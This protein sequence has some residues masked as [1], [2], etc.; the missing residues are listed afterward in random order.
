MTTDRRKAFEEKLAQ[1]KHQMETGLVD[2][3]KTLR[4]AA[5]ALLGGDAE[6]RRT[7]K[8]EGH[9]LRGIAGTYGHEDLTK[10]AARLEQKASLAP[11][12]SVAELAHELADAAERTGRTSVA[13]PRSAP[14][15]GTRPSVPPAE[16]PL[17]P[18]ARLPPNPR[19]PASRPLSGR[20]SSAPT[21]GT[22]RARLHSERPS[23]RSD[24]GGKLRVL[25][26][27][28]EPMTRRLLTLTLRD[29]GG[30][31]AVV[32]DSA[33]AALDE[34]ARREFD[35]V[36][37]DAMMPDMSGKDF[38]IAARKRGGTVAQMPIIILSAAAE[39]E[40]GWM[41]ALPGPV[42]WLRKPFSPRGLVNDVA[43]IVAAHRQ[44]A[45]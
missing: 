30:F 36:I 35:V 11:P 10:L 14:T 33:Q 13:P 18:N 22:G 26:M 3:A 15:T 43:K 1:L 2:R 28:D 23:V 44:K 38:C 39:H 25:A 8:S 27:D 42:S 4:V 34:L 20:R 16:A 37:S 9:K 17:P 40:L 12:A 32:V 21:P 6:A 19:L 29:V 5:A 41:N 24:A 45:R 7:L 31:D